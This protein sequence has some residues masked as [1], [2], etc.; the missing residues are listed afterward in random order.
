MDYQSIAM[1]LLSCIALLFANYF[2]TLHD[3]FFWDTKTKE[4]VANKFKDWHNLK[5]L[6][7]ICFIVSIFILERTPMFLL[8]WLTLRWASWEYFCHNA[9]MSKM[10]EGNGW[11]NRFFYLNKRTAISIIIG[12]I[13]LP[14]ILKTLAKF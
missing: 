12:I 7:I 4:Y 5:Q 2:W 14:I 9:S 10:Y 8:M 13:T 6:M 1:W 11:A 3:W